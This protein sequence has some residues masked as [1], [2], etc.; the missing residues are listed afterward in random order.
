MMSYY[1]FIKIRKVIKNVLLCFL[2]IILQSCNKFFCPDYSNIEVPSTWKTALTIPTEPQSPIPNRFWELFDDPV[3]NH[4]EEQGIKC[5]LDLEAA[6]YRIEQARAL[7]SIETSS[8]FPRIDL[9]T[10]VTRDETLI[11]P[12]DYGVRNP[13]FKRVQQQ[14]YNI[15]TQFSYELDLWGKLKDKKNNLQFREKAFVWERDLIYQTLVTDIALAYFSARTLEAEIQFLKK[16]LDIQ[17]NK[18]KIY[19]SRIEAGVDSG[20]EISRAKSEIGYIEVDLELAIKDLSLQ[21]NKLA[22]L[23]GSVPSSFDL[24]QGD[25]PSEM[26]SVPSILPSEV[27]FKRA[28]VQKY[29]NTLAASHSE[30]NIALKDYFPSFS[31]TGMLGLASPTISSLFDWEGRYWKYL[32]SV[33]EPIFDG[34]KKRGNVKKSKAHFYENFAQ[35]KKSVIQALRDV[36]DSLS[37]FHAVNRQF[38]AQ[39]KS[40]GA[41]QNILTITKNQ[42]EAGLISYILVAEAE[43]NQIEIERKTIILRGEKFLAWVKLIKALGIQ[44]GFV[45]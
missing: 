29:W 38:I 10:S 21:K 17:R 20:L 41:A 30:V 28:D 12:G 43:H 11:D 34:G 13:K 16:A 5:N 26:L 40:L 39:K 14:Q 27:L 18:I 42:F 8:L 7:T 35:Y 2:F 45:E 1:N 15:L 25:F 31:L 9:N 23:I 19:Q 3:L 24:L 32:I 33:L 22:T 36:E 6:F 4:L 37:V 44:N